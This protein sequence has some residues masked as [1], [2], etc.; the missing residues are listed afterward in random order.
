MIA[1]VVAS[2]KRTY[3]QLRRSNGANLIARQL[4]RRRPTRLKAALGEDSRRRDI[5]V[6]IGNMNPALRRAAPERRARSRPENLKLYEG[7]PLDKRISV[8]I[9]PDDEKFVEMEAYFNRLLRSDSLTIR[10]ILEKHFTEHEVEQFI[11]TNRLPMCQW[12]EEN[13]VQYQ[14]ILETQ[15]R[16]KMPTLACKM[17]M[18]WFGLPVAPMRLLSGDTINAFDFSKASKEEDELDEHD[19]EDPE[20]DPMAFLDNQ[21]YGDGMVAGEYG[22]GYPDEAASCP[23]TLSQGASGNESRLRGGGLD[24]EMMDTV[25]SDAEDD[26]SSEVWGK[27]ANEQLTGSLRGG[28]MT[29]DDLPLHVEEMYHIRK[30]PGRRQELVMYGRQGYT[31]YFPSWFG[32]LDAARYLLAAAAPMRGAARVAIDLYEKQSGGRAWT[33]I[34]TAEGPLTLNVV[35]DSPP[36]EGRIMR[37]VTGNMNLGHA[38]D[39]N[40]VCFVRLARDLRADAPTLQGS[41]AGLIELVHEERG[42]RR[43]A[44]MRIPSLPSLE[45]RPSQYS[46]EFGRAMRNLF[47]GDNYRFNLT[48]MKGDAFVDPTPAGTIHIGEDPTTAF[49]SLVARAQRALREA[50]SESHVQFSVTVEPGTPDVI[51][52]LSPQHRVIGTHDKAQLFDLDSLIATAARHVTPSTSL[53]VPIAAF[54]V[55]LPAQSFGDDTRGAFVTGYEGGRPSPMARDGWRR[56]V[57]GMMEAN[58][59]RF[60][61]GFAMM[62][63]P[64]FRWYWLCGELEGG[65]TKHKLINLPSLDLEAFRAVVAAHLYPNEYDPFDQ[66]QV[67]VLRG[68]AARHVVRADS[69]DKDWHRIRRRFA[70]SEIDVEL[71]LEDKTRWERETRWGRYPF[72][73]V[74]R[75]V[76]TH[77]IRC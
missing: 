30:T 6:S 13:T 47:L 67:L 55:Y 54:E 50:N 33:L 53:P 56:Y 68:Q 4:T 45:N 66:N 48:L 11:P 35:P 9:R 59:D 23:L 7:I 8:T 75:A 69:T 52:L 46:E 42:A 15:F 29:Y 5:C 37:F 49:V 41:D 77:L 1:P 64:I 36:E 73:R 71:K 40:R 65:S 57:E 51:P 76:L 26:A 28:G 32:F 60:T 22:E 43:A 39:R 25:L 17:A 12:Q 21:G 10:E 20:E 2:R 18:H 70:E 31:T 63:R 27:Q 72:T 3:H 38:R 16:G 19:R 61:S 44:Y 24:A 58:P 14:D 34:D 74:P 62:V